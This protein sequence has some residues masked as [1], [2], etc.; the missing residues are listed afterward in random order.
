M[1][2]QVV[3]DLLGFE[4]V[5]LLG[6]GAGFIGLN[7]IGL[8]DLKLLWISRDVAQGFYPQAPY[9]IHLSLKGVPM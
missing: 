1:N 6:F 2:L 5:R 8:E 4:A 3:Q 9:G 7:F